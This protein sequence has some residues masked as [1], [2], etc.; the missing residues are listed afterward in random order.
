MSEGHKTKS[1]VRCEHGQFV[2]VRESEC[3]SAYCVAW[4]DSRVTTNYEISSQ[5][6]TQRAGDAEY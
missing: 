6:R 5:Q 1:G 3:D 2:C 4:Q